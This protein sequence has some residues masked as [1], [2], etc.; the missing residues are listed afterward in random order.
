MEPSVCSLGILSLP[1]PPF[2][3]FPDPKAWPLGLILGGTAAS[4]RGGTL[5]TLLHGCTFFGA[6]GN[7]LNPLYSSTHNSK[8]VLNPR[9]SRVLD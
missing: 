2:P 4:L 6:L 5:V 1:S 3:S 8:V 7:V 9:D